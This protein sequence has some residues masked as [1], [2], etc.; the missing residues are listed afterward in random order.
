MDEVSKRVPHLLDYIEQVEKIKQRPAFS[1]Q[2][3]HFVAHQHDLTELPD[4]GFNLQADDEDIWLC[5]PRLQEIP[6]P[7]PGELLKPWLKLS[8]SPKTKPTLRT[9]HTVYDGEQ[10]S[11][12]YVLEEQA[13]IKEHFEWYIENQWE[14][15]AAAER[16]RRKLIKIYKELF[17]LHHNITQGGAETPVELVWGLGYAAWKKLDFNTA[18]RYPLLIQL[19]E[20][21]LDKE[22]FALEVRPRAV[23]SRIEIDCYLEMGVQG[24][25]SLEAYW[26]SS[27]EAGANRFNPFDASTYDGMLKA[28]VGYLDPA[29]SY[30]RVSSGSFLPEPGE[31]LKITNQWVLFARKRS[32]DFFLQDVRRFKAAIAENLAIPNVILDFVKAG[33]DR[34]RA[35]PEYPFRGLSSSAAPAEAFELYFPMPYNDE[36]VSIIQKLKNNDGVVVQ[37]PPGTGKTHTIANV[38]S[39]YLAQGKRVLVTAKSETALDVLQEKLPERIRAL[40]AALLTDERDGLRR[41]EHSIRQIATNVAGLNP[42]RAQSA[43]AAEEEK[44]NQLH[45]QI[46]YV[47]QRAAEYATQ[48]MKEYLYQGSNVMPESLA[49]LVAGQAKEHEWFDDVPTIQANE[50]PFGEEQISWLR[51]ARQKVGERLTYVNAALLPPTILPDWEELQDL[52]RA[53]KA[54][55]EIDDGVRTGG[56]LPLLSTSSE[57]FDKAQE[58]A[59]FLEQ[60]AA[61][62]EKLSGL[63]EWANDL[64]AQLTRLQADDPAWIALLEACQDAQR[65]ERMRRELLPKAIEMPDGAESNEDFNEALRRLAAGRSTFGMPFGKGKARKLIGAVCLLGVAPKSADDWQTIQQL[66]SWRQ[67]VSSLFARWK[68]L[69]GEFGLNTPDTAINSAFLEIVRDADT[70]MYMNQLHTEYEVFLHKRIAGVFGETVADAVAQ[71]GASSISDV[72][73]SLRAHIDKRGL[74][75]AQQKINS[76]INKLQGCNGAV[77]EQL[78][79]FLTEQLGSATIEETK[80]K[81]TLREITVELGQLAVLRPT[82]ERIGQ[83]TAQIKEAGAPNWAMRILEPSTGEDNNQVIPEQWCEAWE[84]RQADIFLLQISGHAILRD[85][86]KEREHLMKMLTQT[87]QE[88]IAQKAWLAVYEKSPDSV[89]QALQAYLG[90]VHAMGAGTGLRAAR[91]RKTAREAMSNAYMAVP[92]WILP[93]WRVSETLPAEMGLFD[94]VVIDEAS[95]SDIFALPALMRAKKILIVG[96]HKQVSPSAVGTAEG[97]IQ[98]LVE[99]FLTKLPHGS[100][101]T[102]DKSIYDLAR[103]VFAGNSVMLQEHF[104]CVPAIIEYSNREFYEGAI[105]PLRVPK[106]NERIDPPLVDVFVHG[107]FRKG[108]TNPAEAKAIVEKIESLLE[109]EE[110][111][112]RT[113]GVVTLRGI[114]QAKHIHE[115]VN[116][117][118][119]PSELLERQ[120]I[121]G[122]PSLFQG[123]ERDIMMVSMVLAPEDKALPNRRDIQQRFNVALSRARDRVYLFRSVSEGGKLPEDSL[124]ARLIRHF[125]KPFMQNEGEIRLLREKCESNFERE[126][127]DELVSRGYRVKPQVSSGG[128]RIDFVVEGDE[129]RRLA[130]ECDGDRFHGPGQW[131]DDMRRQRVLERVGWTFWRCFA[132][133]FV[134]NRDE[135]LA[136]LYG[137]LGKMDI[138]PIGSESVDSTKWVQYVEVDPFGVK[139]KE[140]AIH[141][142]EVMP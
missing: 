29:G 7:P 103:V 139:E 44:L 48:H 82:L 51:E 79:S 80:L 17:T 75:Y 90:A 60:R 71:G 55:S 107:G 112:G 13:H 116:E 12:K 83:L 67:D 24:V 110:F 25:T 57:T 133:S 61:L 91:H 136:D 108:N 109:K 65:L 8:K 50:L 14:P 4:L 86:F 30:E 68:A 129:G 141:E 53:L 34:I 89:R 127:F 137:T 121:V 125:R 95:Q 126:M 23:D 102:P 113:I 142:E 38:I 104:R 52:H 54:A 88:L 85:L 15:W 117:R 37:G 134:R 98:Q 100:E 74:S 131:D 87:Y 93:H 62:E 47:D 35:R 43:I 123:R 42:Q 31:H 101:M 18:L 46:S 28:A 2:T 135:V 128:Y 138:A 49:H 10:N 92:C 27:I 76:L 114:E 132:S 58:L 140:D 130:I 97:R 1:V 26:K 120:I 81:E 36:Q 72:A 118:I 66:A 106:A 99:R 77:M 115:L 96:D 32:S 45:A 9:E 3:E 119:S 78:R 124:N 22:T 41:F 122:D 39:H 105:K 21:A 84:W 33:D 16:P 73:R 59:S 70:I 19:C 111:K 94:L 69:A 11:V 56:L 63:P 20:V 5:I 6:A 40:S 64:Q